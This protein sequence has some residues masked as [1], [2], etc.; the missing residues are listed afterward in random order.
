M[1]GSSGSGKSTFRRCLN[2]LVHSTP[3]ADRAWGA[4]A[5]LQ[6]PPQW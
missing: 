6:A 2:F 5:E 4:G 3:G 1:I